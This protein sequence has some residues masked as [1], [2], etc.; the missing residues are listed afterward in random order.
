MALAAGF[1][2]GG[3]GRD[4][5]P[6]KCPALKRI[7]IKGAVSERLSAP[8]PNEFGGSHRDAAAPPRSMRGS[9]CEI[10]EP[11]KVA[12]FSTPQKIP[13]FGLQR[14]A[15]AEHQLSGGLHDNSFRKMRA[16]E[17]YVPRDRRKIL[18]RPMRNDG[19]HRRNRM[20]LPASGVR[21][22]QRSQL[23]RRGLAA[24]REI[25]SDP[26]SQVVAHFRKADTGRSACA[27]GTVACFLARV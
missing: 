2:P 9:L 3:G 24:V 27:T 22:P 13:A 14:A 5:L 18:Q 7:V 25:E 23:E 1:F 20:R 10:N 4:E 15:H 12:T 11:S 21:R 26:G 16:P 19:R 8:P 17:L 6:K